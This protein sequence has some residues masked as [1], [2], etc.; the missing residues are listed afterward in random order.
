MKTIKK[1]P[2]GR[3]FALV[4]SILGLSGS[5]GRGGE[6]LT[7]SHVSTTEM[8]VGTHRPEIRVRPDGGLMVVVVQPSPGPNEVGRIKHQAYRF[9]PDLQQ[10]GDPFPVAAIDGTYGEPA[11]HRAILVDDE[12]VVVYQTL[13]YEEGRP[14]GGGG[15]PS[16]DFATDQSLMLARF[17]L[18][19][20]ELMREP[21]IALATDFTQDNFPDH[22]MLWSGDR[23]LLST[24]TRANLLKIR[25][26]DLDGDVLATHSI[27]T[28]ID[29]IHGSIGNSMHLNDGQVRFVS[30]L[31]PVGPGRITVNALD[32]AFA[33]SRLAS[34]GDDSLERHFPTDSRV[35]GDCTLVTYIARAVGGD[36][37][38]L[39][40]PYG[41]R[42]AVL[43]ASLEL[44][45]DIAV[46]EGGFSHVHPTMAYLGDRLYVA[47]SKRSENGAPQVQVERYDL[48]W[49]PD[50]SIEILDVHQ[51]SNA[52]ELRLNFTSSPGGRYLVEVSDDLVTWQALG[53][54]VS[55]GGEQTAYT[56]TGLPAVTFRRF[57]RIKKN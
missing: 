13:N 31:G 5:E 6:R 51:G 18:E 29:G 57:Y 15:G 34:V 11:D 38:M 42:L 20:N 46:G 35:V 10:E 12:L 30:S 7:L 23:L 3:M 1:L 43:D 4:L 45:D 39:A 24:G 27:P 48:T 19:G 2:G 17:D 36:P 40:N 55:S 26:V 53:D 14:V 49:T 28:S 32:D 56:I 22:C 16:E 25:E 50:E 8:A 41:V 52:R 33:V 9:D 21:I 37:D 44:V 54:A 47:W